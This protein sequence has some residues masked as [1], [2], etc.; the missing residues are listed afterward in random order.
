MLDMLHGSRA[1]SSTKALISTAFRISVAVL[2]VGLT[3]DQLQA[4][5]YTWIVDASGD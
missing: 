1:N 3:A 2:I 4:T 5:N